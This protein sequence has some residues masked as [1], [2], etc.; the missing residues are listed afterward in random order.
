MNLN[1]VDR[2]SKNTLVSNITKTRPVGAE[3]LHAV[4]RTDR[5]NEAD[6]RFSQFYESA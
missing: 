4:G 2:F 5:H 3:L 1:F 6:S